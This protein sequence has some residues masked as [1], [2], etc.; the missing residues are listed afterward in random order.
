MSG[1]QSVLLAASILRCTEGSGNVVHLVE[2][3]PRT[4]DALYKP[5]MEPNACCLSTQELEE[6]GAEGQGHLQLC[7]MFEASLGYVDPI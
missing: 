5:G 1:V 2:R 6:R 3:W 7:I 4:D